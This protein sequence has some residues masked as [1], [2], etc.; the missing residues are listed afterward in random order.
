MKECPKCLT[1]LENDKNFCTKCGA[2]QEGGSKFSDHAKK[3]VGLPLEITSVQHVTTPK[4]APKIKKVKKDDGAGK[5]RGRFDA[6][7]GLLSS[8]GK[9]DKVAGENIVPAKNPSVKENLPKPD[10]SRATKAAPIKQGKEK[11][12]KIAKKKG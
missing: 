1:E 6:I 11:K 3:R 7:I 2:K 4:N 10:P 12:V 8:F 9:K 5:K